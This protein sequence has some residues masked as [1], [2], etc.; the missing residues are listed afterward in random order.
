MYGIYV[1][2]AF[3]VLGLSTLALVTLL[4]LPARTRA[5]IA[6]AIARLF[7]AVAGI[8]VAVAGR[9]WLPAGPCVV[10]A[11]HASYVD[12]VLLKAFLPARFSFV[13]K[14]EITRVP[15]AGLLLRRIGSE[16]VD[17][18]SR[19]AAAMDTRRL[20][21]AADAGQAFAF[22]PE[23]TFNVEPGVGKFHSG[24]FVI[25]A[26]AGMPVVPVAIRGTRYL[27]PGGRVLPRFH[28]LIVDILPPVTAT[29]GEVSAQALRDEA[30]ARIVAIVKEP[31]LS[32]IDGV[33]GLRAPRQVGGQEGESRADPRV[34]SEGTGE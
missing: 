32:G 24:A 28:K 3:V 22:F 34:A 6:H 11:N 26:K 29:G 19:T 15:L 16:F 4:P 21:K 27:L 30:R 33:A 8:R 20:I 25:A 1:V 17:R 18:F 10:V 12:G 9:E 23:G 13:I 31:D 5:G 2:V 7:F 14:K